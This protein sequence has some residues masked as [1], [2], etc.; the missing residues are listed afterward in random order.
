VVL[1]R[2]WGLD[3]EVAGLPGLVRLLRLEEAKIGLGWEGSPGRVLLAIRAVGHTEDIQGSWGSRPAHQE[4][5]AHQGTR[6]EEGIHDLRTEDMEDIEEG[7]ALDQ[8][9]EVGLGLVAA[10]ETL[11]LVV[12]VIVED[13]QP[14]L[15]WLA[16]CQIS[17][18]LQANR[19]LC[20]NVI[21]RK[22]TEI[23]T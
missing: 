1:V 12:L 21:R 3:L 6:P 5:G 9:L 20:Q 7:R 11:D 8:S 4:E 10:V 17:L 18:T 22:A 16:K 14:M 15:Q 2:P 23:S 13:E 19:A